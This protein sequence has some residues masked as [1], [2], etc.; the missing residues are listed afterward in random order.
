MAS[1]ETAGK[2]TKS[3]ASSG[4]NGLKLGLAAVLIVASVA[5]LGYVFWPKADVVIPVKDNPANA[6]M[7]AY[8]QIAADHA[9][10]LDDVYKQSAGMTVLPKE[11]GSGIVVNGVAPS[12][13]FLD[14]FKKELGAIQPSV[15]IEWNVTVGR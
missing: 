14:L 2:S 3:K 4:G 5:W 6:W 9:K 7:T 12:Q 13:A 8:G 10:K 15:P 11:D 1:I